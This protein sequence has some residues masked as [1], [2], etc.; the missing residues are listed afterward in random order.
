MH[1]K[2]I[3]FIAFTVLILGLTACGGGT[4]ATP[5][6]PAPNVNWDQI[7]WDRDNWS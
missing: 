5:P 6:P 3:H 1:H 7:Q 2:L 4:T